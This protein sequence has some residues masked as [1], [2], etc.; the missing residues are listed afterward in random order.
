MIILDTSKSATL[1]H[2]IDD[3]HAFLEAVWSASL[4]PADGTA[5][6]KKMFEAIFQILKD[7]DSLGLIIESYQL[8]NGLDKRYPRVYFSGIEES[9][10]SSSSKVVSEVMVVKRVWSPFSF[11]LDIAAS[12]L[13]A[14]R[15]SAGRIDPLGFHSLIEN[16]IKIAKVKRSEAGETKSIGQMLLFQYLVSVLEG[17]FFPRNHAFKENMNWNLLRQSILNMI[18]GS[19]KIMYKS[20]VRDCVSVLCEFSQDEIEFSL[21]P[22]NEDDSLVELPKNCDAAIEL[23][24]PEIEKTTCLAMKKLLLMIMELDSSR[25]IADMNG[26]ITRADGARISP[27]EIILDELI[28]NNNLLLPFFMAFDAHEWNL[29]IIL[30]YFQKYIPKSSGRT[31]R[32]NGSASDA[33]LEGILKCLSNGA[34]AKSITK[35]MGSGIAQLLLAHAFQAYLSVPSHHHH[36]PVEDISDPKTHDRGIY[37]VETCKSLVSAFTC[38]RREDDSYC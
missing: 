28:Y 25:N 23:G 19:R 11:G 5:P 34:T 30:Q 26:L 18:L 12:E 27:T 2:L 15:N 33:T 20:F 36:H 29:K 6:T 37:L 10:S 32:S 1:H 13:E 35:K 16:L 7:E 24:L 17:D 22:I 14:T 31:R 3:R 21:N 4:V 9:E 38:L 8:L